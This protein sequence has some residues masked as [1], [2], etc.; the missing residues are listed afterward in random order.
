MR[1]TVATPLAVV[2]DNAEVAHVRAED[3]SGAF[4]I[5]RGHADFVTS[6]AVSVVSWRGRDRAEHHVAVRGGVLQVR[7]GDTIEIATREAVASDDL[8][9]L[10]SEVLTRFRAQLQDERAASSD[11]R[12]LY[13]AAIREIRRFLRPD[14]TVGFGTRDARNG[15]DT[16]P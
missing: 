16:A 4:G 14:Q 5:L 3:D 8:L 2:V 13:L 12:R 15:N 7:T 6:L 9:R 10:E 11:S 1:L